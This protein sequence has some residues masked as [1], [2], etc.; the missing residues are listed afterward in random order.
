MEYQ[1]PSFLQSCVSGCLT[2]IFIRF[3]L[4]GAIFLAGIVWY[5]VEGL[6]QPRLSTSSNEV[7]TIPTS[8]PQGETLA[9]VR[10][11][12]PRP[13]RTATTAD[14]YGS[15]MFVT[16]NALFVRSG[17]GSEYDAIGTLSHCDT[18]WLLALSG[19]GWVHV[20]VGLLDGYEGYVAEK[21]V[22]ARRGDCPP[23]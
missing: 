9:T 14:T 5:T 18:V 7:R 17:P 23:P 12:T 2:R 10:P 13:S 4:A 21:Y 16:A 3:F 11:F 22:S 1:R 19:N 20:K 15:T 8:R 6:F